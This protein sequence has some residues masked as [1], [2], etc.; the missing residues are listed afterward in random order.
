MSDIE[1]LK[2]DLERASMVDAYWDRCHELVAEVER[3]RAKMIAA[4]H[5]LQPGYPYT[6]NTF[7]EAL[8]AVTE[9]FKGTLLANDYCHAEIARLRAERDELIRERFDTIGSLHAE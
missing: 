8:W 9:G 7:D 1:K 4:A 3:L 2:D 5:E 6:Q